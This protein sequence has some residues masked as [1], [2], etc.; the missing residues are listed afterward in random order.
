MTTLSTSWVW[1]LL[2]VGTCDLSMHSRCLLVNPELHGMV[3]TVLLSLGAD[4]SWIWLNG[5]NSQRHAHG[6]GGYPADRKE[7]TRDRGEARELDVSQTGTRVRLHNSWVDSYG[8]AIY[9]WVAFMSDGG[10][11]GRGEKEGRETAARDREDKN[12]LCLKRFFIHSDHNAP[13]SFTEKDKESLP[14]A[15]VRKH[16]L[17][18]RALLVRSSVMSMCVCISSLI[19]SRA[20][21]RST[22]QYSLSK[23]SIS[24]ASWTWEGQSLGS[25]H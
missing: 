5:I 7:G 2:S 12:T 14:L 20:A 23:Q 13:V 9:D 1:R 25:V 16:L 4:L 17:L 11:A 19:S 3:W 15:A 6:F 10:K 21:Y 24:S 18:P 8:P 22:S